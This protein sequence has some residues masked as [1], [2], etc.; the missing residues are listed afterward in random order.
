MEDSFGYLHYII[1]VSASFHCPR[2][3]NLLDWGFILGAFL[4]HGGL[5]KS[6]NQTHDTN[7][8]KNIFNEQNIEDL[9]N[10]P[11][12]KTKEYVENIFA[13]KFGNPE[14][15]VVRRENIFGT[16]TKVVEKKE[17]ST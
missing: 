1:F 14:G 8:H 17:K 13:S 11:K 5:K 4:I 2:D 6:R 15:I 12:D 3:K 7:N 10:L 9:K 16:F